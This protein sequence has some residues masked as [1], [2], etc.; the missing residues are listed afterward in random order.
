MNVVAGRR[1]SKE[2]PG[3]LCDVWSE[4]NPDRAAHWRNLVSAVAK[5]VPPRFDHVGATIT[6]SKTGGVRL[7][8]APMLR[9]T[10]VAY[11]PITLFEH[12]SNVAANCSDDIEKNL[13][14]I[15]TH[16]VLVPAPK[17]RIRKSRQRRKRWS[18]SKWPARLSASA[19]RRSTKTTAA[20][21]TRRPSLASAYDVTY[22]GAG[23]RG[24]N[25]NDRPEAF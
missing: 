2:I 4:P 8:L 17:F 1:S 21:T 7:K 24:A 23:V 25:L 5:Y 18:A 22:S 16:E 20:R 15:T 3:V 10:A 9:V 13:A 11:R 19:T 14:Q 6:A 12:A